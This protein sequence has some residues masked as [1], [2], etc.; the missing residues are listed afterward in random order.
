MVKTVTLSPKLSMVF[1]LARVEILHEKLLMRIIELA[2]NHPLP[3]HGQNRRADFLQN[4]TDKAARGWA[5][6]KHIAMEGRADCTSLEIFNGIDNDSEPLHSFHW[7]LDP[8]VK[9]LKIKIISCFISSI[10]S[11]LTVQYS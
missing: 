10:F 2:L 6:I 11:S 4:S 8:E 3:D 1:H 5:A 7:L 9:F